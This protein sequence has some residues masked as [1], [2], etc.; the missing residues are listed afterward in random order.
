VLKTLAGGQSKFEID[1]RPQIA[2]GR[3]GSCEHRKQGGC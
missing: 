3:S 2:I 1:V